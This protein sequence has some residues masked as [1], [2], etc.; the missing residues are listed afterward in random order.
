MIKEEVLPPGCKE[1]SSGSDKVNVGTCSNEACVK[2]N[3][4]GAGGCGGQTTPMC[5]SGTSVV[6]SHVTCGNG[7]GFNVQKIQ[8]C[9]CAPCIQRAIFIHGRVV[10]TD[11]KAVR[12]AEIRLEGVKKLFIADSEGYFTVG[13][14]PGTR[15]VVLTVKD[16]RFMPGRHIETSKAFTLH[17]G[18]T[19]FYTIVLQKSPPER[20]FKATEEQNI[21]LGTEGSRPSFVALRIPPEA[22]INKDGS[23]YR[24]EVTSKIGVIDPRNGSDM[25]SAPG[26]FS[27]VDENGEEIMLGTAG[28]LR[29]TY[30]DANGKRLSLSKN[31]TVQLDSD[32]LQIPDGVT[33]Y[34]W[35]LSKQ[36]GRWV[37][38]GQLREESVSRRKRQARKFWV[39]DITPDIPSDSINWD[40]VATVSYVRV[41]APA[42]AVVTRIGRDGGQYTSYRQETVPGN[43]LLC[44]RAIRDKAAILQADLS[45]E[46]LFPVTPVGFPTAVNP[47]VIDGSAAGNP[48]GIRS[49]LFTSTKVNDIGPVYLKGEDGRCSQ[50]LA[51][52]LAFQFQRAVGTGLSFRWTSPRTASWYPNP[53]NICFVKVVIGGSKPES[54][55]YLKS[56]G[57]G[58]G[59]NVDYGYTA[60]KATRVGN[61]GVVCLEYRCGEG[62]TATVQTHLQLLSL[63]GN[64]GNIR[65]NSVLAGAQCFVQPDPDSQREEN[66]CIP[67]DLSGGNAGLYTG[68]PGLALFRCEAGNNQFSQGPPTL[69]ANAPTVQLDCK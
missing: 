53:N 69:T 11:R 58:G 21:P 17:E 15:R 47:S 57:K 41:L 54:V 46:P 25:A 33:V 64:C 4:G 26:D 38:F 13:V 2:R 29:Q 19:S 14:M 40:Y 7:I 27:A 43:G 1:D 24:G 59:A 20:K 28:I 32:Q 5:C 12:K 62:T 10:D 48:F 16:S 8:R 49:I 37:K 34:Q 66:F 22:F 6:D 39:A 9:S 44:M 42:G 36:T 68:D 67:N 55:L 52:D 50:N 51:G 60:E 63:T 45:G 23:I 31:I 3:Q 65:V 18:Q 61:A 30:S 56:T 35:Y